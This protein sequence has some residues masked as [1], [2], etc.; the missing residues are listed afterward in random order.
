MS[1]LCL[2]FYFPYIFILAYTSH[3]FIV[4]LTLVR[5]Q[6]SV[7]WSKINFFPT[8]LSSKTKRSVGISNRVWICEQKSWWKI[9][10]Y[11]V[12]NCRIYGGEL[13]YIWWK[14]VAY[15]D[16]IVYSTHIIARITIITVRQRFHFSA[17]VDIIMRGAL[18]IEWCT[19]GFRL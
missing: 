7:K 10:V 17:I 4:I 14:I 1:Q 19:V 15:T 11:V 3:H 18:F 8:I 5:W 2:M 9:V 12:E 16:C 13:S 6:Y